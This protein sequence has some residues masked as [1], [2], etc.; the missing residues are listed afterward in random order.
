MS[1]PLRHVVSLDEMLHDY[2]PRWNSSG[3]GEDT[4]FRTRLTWALARF[5]TRFERGTASVV[6]PG[7]I[8]VHA[9]ADRRHVCIIPR[10]PCGRGVG[11]GCLSLRT[12]S[13]SGQASSRVIRPLHAVFA[14]TRSSPP[15]ACMNMTASRRCC[16][17]SHESLRRA[18][19]DDSNE[20]AH[21]HFPS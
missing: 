18:L 10:A 4:Y 6:L 1:D 5:E 17:K 19:R 2:R 8:L 11:G 9:R 7:S 16:L 12:T 20:A 15:P 13:Y 21:M 3:E 14:K